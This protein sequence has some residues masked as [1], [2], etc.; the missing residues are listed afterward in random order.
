MRGAFLERVKS[1]AGA[2][3]LAG[4]MVILYEHVARAGVQVSRLCGTAGGALPAVVLSATRVA[5]AYAADHQR[6]LED[7]FKQIF[8]SCWPLVLVVVGT[9]LSRDGLPDEATHFQKE[10]VN[11]SI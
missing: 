3:L 1:I 10:I 7:F 2:A 8:A 5:Q 9:V 6:F 11:L 4:G